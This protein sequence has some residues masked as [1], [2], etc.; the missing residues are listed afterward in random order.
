[1]ESNNA[2]RRLCIFSFYDPHGV[3]DDYVLYFLNALREH[4]D[5]ILFYSNGP[6][7]R[8]SNAALRNTVTEVIVRPNVGFDVLAYK[9]GL[10]KV[11]FGEGSDYDEILMVNHTCYGPLFPFGELFGAM[12][13]RNCDFWGVTAHLAMTP[14]PFTGTGYLPY[15]LNTNFVA[16]RSEMFR[17]ASFKSYWQQIEGKGSYESAI[18][19]HEASFTEHFTKLGYVCDSY[20]DCSKYGTH[21][22]AILDVDET[23]ADR[24]PLLKR[25][26]FFHDPRF[27]EHY[28][29][30]LPRALRTLEK[31]SAYDRSLLW[32]NVAR[33]GEPR[34]LNT[35]AALTSVLPN[36]RLKEGEA[37]PYAGR[38]AVCVHV[39]YTDMLDEILALSDTIPCTYDF[40]ATTDNLTKKNIIEQRLRGRANVG[41]VIVRVVEQNRGRDM[42]ALLIGCRDLFLDERYELVCRLHTKKT[43]HMSAGR[44]N[45]FKRHMFENLLSSHGYTSNVL[46]MF[47]DKPW[48]GLAVP[49]II[50]MSYGTLGHA[51]GV[52]RARTAEVATMLGLD[53][54]LDAD[55]PVGAFGGMFWFR[56]RALRKLFAHHWRW[57]NFEAEP[58]PL[59]GTL[60]HALER[61]I[62]YVAQ[63]AGFITQQIISTQLAGWNF[64][65]L[66]YKL[67]KL[68]SAI[69]NGSFTDQV[70]F[71]ENCT[72]LPIVEEPTPAQDANVS[73]AMVEL[74]RAVKR[75]AA[76]RLPRAAAAFRPIYRALQRQRVQK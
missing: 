70:Q 55:T 44:S 6:L 2:M 76:H 57:E 54:H 37:V 4:V 15:H 61:L 7:A 23:I 18:M 30:D 65:M 47:H 9:E 68:S 66:E 73:N 29:A 22:P 10:Q 14:N 42:S 26:A 25:R 39:Y 51:W 48:V 28:A 33:S 75:S 69:P 52:N 46:D 72:R 31:T 60:G 1:M 62:T 40:I 32:R 16:V 13:K 17:S 24:N 27:L 50:Q 34:N 12:Q 71:I 63:D 41:N 20:L 38:I 5:T 45:V 59:D 67:Q 35:N 36:V 58:Y 19:E 8:E 53:V 64:A 43:P 74:M 11:R 56:P 3:V 21:Y 49:T